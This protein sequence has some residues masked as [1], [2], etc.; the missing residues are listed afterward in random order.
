[1]TLP[2]FNKNCRE[3]EESSSE[4][5]E[6]SDEESSD[7]ESDEEG[8][9][10]VVSL[11]KEA[12]LD[13]SECTIAGCN[14]TFPNFGVSNKFCPTHAK[15]CNAPQSRTAQIICEL[16][17]Y[18]YC[19]NSDAESNYP[20]YLALHNKLFNNKKRK[21]DGDD[22]KPSPVYDLKK[23]K[24]VFKTMTSK[25][26]MQLIETAQHILFECNLCAQKRKLK[27]CVSCK[28]L[29][30]P[31]H[32]CKETK[33]CF[34]CEG[35]MDKTTTNNLQLHLNDQ[36]K[37]LIHYNTFRENLKNLFDKDEMNVPEL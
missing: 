4:E 2:K 18:M 15:G 25:H 11:M 5:S 10:D 17:N 7:E 12:G 14:K 36:R 26:P 19:R 37:L 22:S 23:F 8:D 13:Y 34:A 29:I 32:F 16:Y 33:Q 28:F 21:R 3:R 24:K 27:M 6:E 9:E 35:R 31:D 30:C 1:M 20:A